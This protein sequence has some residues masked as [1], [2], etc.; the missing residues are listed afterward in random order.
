ME[1]IRLR[2]PFEVGDIPLA[3]Y[4]RPQFA[5]DSY[6]TL[7]GKWDYAIL[8]KSETFGGVYQ[9]KILVP[10]SPESLLSGLDEGISVGVDDKLYY[11]RTFEVPAG[12]LKART[13]LHF[14]AVD[15]WCKVTLNGAIRPL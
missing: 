10:F 15:F 4:P 13:I 14:G 1:T 6:L 12:F 2:T 5:R 7:N 3:E 9:G 8:R 11:H